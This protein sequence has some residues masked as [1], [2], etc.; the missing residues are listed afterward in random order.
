M[1]EFSETEYFYLHDGYLTKYSIGIGIILRV[2]ELVLM[3]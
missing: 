2:M 1:V 3:A